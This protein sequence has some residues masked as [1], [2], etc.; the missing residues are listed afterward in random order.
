MT[1]LEKETAYYWRV[2]SEAAA[3]F[4]QGRRDAETVG[5]LLDD[6]SA[7]ATHTESANLRDAVMRATV[8]LGMPTDKTATVRC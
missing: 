6:L 7:I 8:V 2:T 5:E 4:Q 1:T 3:K